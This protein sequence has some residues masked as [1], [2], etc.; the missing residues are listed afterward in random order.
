VTLRAVPVWLHDRKSPVS[1]RAVSDGPD[2][3]NAPE[4]T[5][6]TP[7]LS[8][9]RI[10][11]ALHGVASA[12]PLTGAG[13]QVDGPPVGSVE[14]TALPFASTATQSDTDG[15]AIALSCDAW[16]IVVLVHAPDA[17]S[18]EISSAPAAPTARQSDADGQAIPSRLSG[19][20]VGVQGPALGSVVV[21]TRSVRPS[22]ATQ[23]VV[24]GHVPDVNGGVAG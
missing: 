21:R 11:S 20:D 4:S 5:V 1:L 13:V 17:G 24:V 7:V 3:G 15:H 22:T 18:V 23:W 14:V 2:P 12:H 6:C 9:A 10:C 16:S 8:D 19:T